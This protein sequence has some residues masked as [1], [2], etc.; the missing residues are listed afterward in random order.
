MTELEDTLRSSALAE[1][2]RREV[3]L[4]LG[5]AAEVEEVP[6]L[7]DRLARRLLRVEEHEQPHRDQW[8][9]YEHSFSESYLSGRLWTPEIDLWA[10][11]RR[12]ELARDHVLEPLWPSGLRFAVCSTHDVDMVSRS[13]TPAQLL[14][15]IRSAC[16]PE[17]GT[18]DAAGTAARFERLQRPVRAVARGAYFGVARAPDAGDSLERAIAAE[19]ELGGKGS[20]L[21]T[22]VPDRPV[23]Y[24]CVY[25]HDDACTFRGRRRTVSAVM[26]LL[27]DEGFD[28]GLHGSWRSALDPAVLASERERLSA[29][30]DGAISSTRQHYL[31]YDARCTARF[32][33]RAGL[34]VDSTLGFNRN[35][36][37]RAG[38]SLPFRQFD[39]RAQTSMHLLEV[40]LVIQEAALLAA[41][42]L[43]L[44][45]ALARE[46]IRTI[47]DTVAEASGV[48]TLLFHPHSLVDDSVDELYRFSLRYAVEVGG[49]LTS[50]RE[51]ER[52]WRERAEKLEGDTSR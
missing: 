6:V 49:W 19:K 22:V 21:F 20:Y 27:R 31:H 1:H 24:D 29:A 37:F 44:D 28:V 5:V 16:A 40:P 2:L 34:S 13:M 15:S 43:E 45:H 25:D 46:V 39:L 52:W 10:A 35:I 14:R 41:N 11:E 38:T 42:A 36:G 18:A 50:L 3:R 51:L 12:R 9:C 8:G 23:H 33:D 7:P 47:I 48:V 4:W 30:V 17:P 32:Q 26:R